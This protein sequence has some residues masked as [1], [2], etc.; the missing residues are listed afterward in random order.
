MRNMGI[1]R[2][3]R[4]NTSVLAKK[5]AGQKGRLIFVNDLPQELLAM[6]EKI[7]TPWASDTYLP[8]TY[9]PIIL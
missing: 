1:T 2:L 8:W 9:L 4:I 3:L 5:E 7:M 6:M